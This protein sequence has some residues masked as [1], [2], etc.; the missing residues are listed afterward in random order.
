MEAQTPAVIHHV[1]HEASSSKFKSRAHK[2]K[3]APFISSSIITFPPPPFVISKFI[4]TCIWFDGHSSGLAPVVAGVD[5][6]SNKAVR[7][8]WAVSAPAR[9]SLP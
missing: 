5:S 9:V 6:A 7:P 4:P 2:N 3:V 1:V 8:S